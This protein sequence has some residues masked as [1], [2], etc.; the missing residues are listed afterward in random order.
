M[1]GHLAVIKSQISSLKLDFTNAND[2]LKKE[3]FARMNEIQEY[4]D[5]KLKEHEAQAKKERNQIM[6]ALKNTNGEIIALKKEVASLAKATQ[7]Q[8]TPPTAQTDLTSTPVRDINDV[9]V[10]VDFLAERGSGLPCYSTNVYF[11]AQKVATFP[12]LTEG[13]GRQ[14]N[15]EVQLRL[16]KGAKLQEKGYAML[17]ETVDK[18]WRSGLLDIRYQTTHDVY[19]AWFQRN[20]YKGHEEVLTVELKVLWH[21]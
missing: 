21:A 8:Q 12:Q 4:H 5:K 14:L 18:K 2:D 6:G 7:Q 10:H 15:E 16:G 13:I 3:I 19:H 11:P 1:D 17:L 20:V 9:L